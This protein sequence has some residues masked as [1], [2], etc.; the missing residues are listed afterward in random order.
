VKNVLLTGGTGFVGANLALRLLRNGHGVAL[1][2][3]PGCATWRLQS[4]ADDVTLVEADLTDARSMAKAL[5][6]LR[7]DWIS[8]SPPT[9]PI[10]SSRI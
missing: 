9:A 8:T 10:P 2:V 6:G 7:P 5:R 4:F 1:I 3:R